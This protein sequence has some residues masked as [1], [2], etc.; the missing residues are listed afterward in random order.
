MENFQFDTARKKGDKRLK[1]RLEII[2]TNVIKIRRIT[3]EY[4]HQL[5]AN[6]LDY[7]NEMDKF[8][9]KKKTKE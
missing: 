6:N 8:L 1:P 2:I 9:E 5:P 4:D 3:R 7:L